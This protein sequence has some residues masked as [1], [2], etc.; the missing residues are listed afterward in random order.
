[1]TSTTTTSFAEELKSVSN[2]ELDNMLKWADLS[3][4]PSPIE[5]RGLIYGERIRRHAEECSDLECG[6]NPFS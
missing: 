3:L 2:T 4:D 6:F 5:L 1:M